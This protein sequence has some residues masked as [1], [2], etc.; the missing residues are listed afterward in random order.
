ML[1]GGSRNVL[2]SLR[3]EMK[4]SWASFAQGET[5]G[6]GDFNVSGYE[7]FGHIVSRGMNT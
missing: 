4:Y 3:D 2:E 6:L 5:K 7:T 1:H